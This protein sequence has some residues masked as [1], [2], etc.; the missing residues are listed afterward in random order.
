MSDTELVMLCS[1]ESRAE[2]EQILDFL[3]ENGIRAEGQ[4]GVR[5]IYAGNA[6]Y[7]E[8]I[9][10]SSGDLERARVLMQGL[11]PVQIAEKGGEEQPSGAKKALN[12]IL[13]AVL[14]V[15]FV[16]AVAALLQQ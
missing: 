2:S 6:L 10:V 13:T 4:G 14:F 3:K 12:W 15:I 11:K 16:A 5:D 7:G 8:Q 1:T 9:M